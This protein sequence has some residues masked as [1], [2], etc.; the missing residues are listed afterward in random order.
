MNI[1]QILE[2]MYAKDS[3]DKDD[4]RI[5]EQEILYNYYTGNKNAILMYLEQAALKSYH[6]D[7]VN[8]MQ[9]LF[10]NVAKK[11]INQLA[12]I[13]NEPAERKLVKSDGKVDEKATDYYLS[14]LPDNINTIDKQAHRYAKLFNTSMTKVF[15]HKGKIKY[16]VPP[17]HLIRVN[18]D[19]ETQD[20][21]VLTYERMIGNDHY[22]I[23]WTEDQHFKSLNGT[24]DPESIGDNNGLV[25]PYGV[26]TYAKLQLEQMIDFWGE[27][28]SDLAVISETINLLKSL[29]VSDQIIYGLSGGL[30]A[31]DIHEPQFEK[32]TG[33]QTTPPIV[34]LNRKRPIVA[35]TGANGLKP[36]ITSI[37]TNP[38]IKEVR[39][40]IDWFIRKIAASKGLNPNSF[41]DGV[42]ATSG[43]SK[44]ID[45]LEQLDIRR[46]DVEPC[47][48]YEQERFGITRIVNNVHSGEKGMK[49]IPEDLRLQ[50]DFKEIEIPKTQD[51]IIAE[52]EF[53]KAHNLSTPIDW[54]M[55]KNPDI[56]EDTAKEIIEK[57]KEINTTIGNNEPES[58]IDR[59]ARNFNKQN[60]VT[61]G[62]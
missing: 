54:L 22:V 34:R 56:D 10:M 35:R 57:N 39:E 60:E 6:P 27:P 58:A 38:E 2:L 14:I 25:N 37:S 50:V 18:A 13:Y 43:Y 33:K 29:L 11:I 46:D 17:S 19:P 32:G 42:K 52:R 53:E 5:K 12:I 49:K 7:D 31:T 9:K 16:I 4:L 59:I 3:K 55:E 28:M 26:I 47:R 15:M 23:V 40:T 51:E 62:Q 44:I 1:K 36:E 20:L 24:G 30:L 21:D 45:S 48:I 61:S 41:L 8:E